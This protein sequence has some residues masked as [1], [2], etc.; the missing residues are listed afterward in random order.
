MTTVRFI[1]RLVPLLAAIL[2]DSISYTIVVPVLAAA[3]VSDNPLLMAGQ[4]QSIRYIVYGVA[5]GVF[6]LMMLY[7]APVL[8]E[9]SDRI[10]RR[11]VL[12]ACL[13]GVAASFVLIGGAI[14][15]DIVVLLLLGRIL[16]GAMAGSQAVAQAAAVDQSDEAT[17]P[18]ALSLCLFASSV[19]FIL[20]PLIGGAMAYAERPTA[21]DFTI[22]IGVTAL[23]ALLAVALTLI[24]YREAVRP[25][26]QRLRLR[27]VDLL[28]GVRGF[29]AAL[30][31]PVIRRVVAIFACMQVAWGA[32][33]LFLPSLLFERFDLD[34]GTVSLMMGLL[35]VGFCAAYGLCLPW[36]Q[37]RLAARTI[38]AWSL[39]GTAILMVVS[40]SSHDLAVQWAV[41]FP[42][43]TVVSI[44]YG[45]IIT[46]FSD[47]VESD[48]QGWILGISISVTA[49]AWGSSSIV[50]GMLSGLDYRAPFVLALLAMVAS[51]GLAVMRSARPAT[52]LQGE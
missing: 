30:V 1:V 32:Y 3:L 17:K 20:G 22:P 51:A 8:G 10:G 12:V 14:L 41:A 4:S 2:I 47:A 42:I 48:R 37:K 52:Q 15:F 44:A 19:G 21:V 39:W 9:I 5:L 13:I 16:G 35:G 7:M 27:D 38:A 45:A 43:A 49:L 24:W 28:M 40:V 25:H 36:L 6:E 46:Q 11:P 29:R 34:T 23:L 18:L 26:A 33:F 50:A 31:D